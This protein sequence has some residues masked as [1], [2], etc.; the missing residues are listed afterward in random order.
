MSSLLEIA[1]DD[2]ARKE[3]RHELFSI[4]TK[5]SSSFFDKFISLIYPQKRSLLDY[6][7]DSPASIVCDIAGVRAKA[8]NAVELNRELSDALVGACLVS[9]EYAAYN[10]DERELEAFFENEQIHK[11]HL[12]RHYNHSNH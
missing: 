9:E 2:E 7:V 5:T 4:E 10:D 3:L 12:H 1:R 8:K 11:P 6:F